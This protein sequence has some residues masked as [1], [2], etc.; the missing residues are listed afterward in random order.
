MKQIKTLNINGEDYKIAG[1]SAYEIAGRNGF[2]G[3]EEEWLESLHADDLG[4]IN[5]ALDAIIE[6]QQSL[7]HG[8]GGDN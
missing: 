3:T 7:I 8:F 6:I 5:T 4:D 1:E 2:E